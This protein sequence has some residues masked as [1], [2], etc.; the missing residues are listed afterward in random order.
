MSDSVD[1]QERSLASGEL[2]TPYELQVLKAL[3]Q[4]IR[5]VDLHSRRLVAQ[6][7]VTG[8]QLIC[9]LTLAESEPLTPS[10]IALEVHLAR[11]TVNGILDRLEAKQLVTRSRD[12]VNRRHVLVYLT[13]RGRALTR[14]A[15]SPLQDTLATALTQL[16][17]NEQAEIAH[18]LKRLVELMHAESVDAA[19]ILETGNIAPN[20]TIRT[21]NKD[22]K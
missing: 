5:A 4:I 6:H 13:D 19:P 17:K 14:A 20:P 10:T 21:H 22:Q 2:G 9:L 15:P 11:S 7:D 16:P 3:R 1:S 18:S 8:P 12:E